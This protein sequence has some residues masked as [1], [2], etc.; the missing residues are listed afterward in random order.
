MGS[1]SLPPANNPPQAL[2]DLALT[3]LIEDRIEK[4]RGYLNFAQE[5]AKKDREYFKYLFDRAVWF[6]GFIVIVAGFLGFR[7]LEQIK[8][9][10]NTLT[11]TEM[12]KA[13]GEL[14]TMRNSVLATTD[15]LKTT[16]KRELDNVRVEVQKRVN[17]E[18][19]TDNITALVTAAAKERTQS[20]LAGTIRSETAKQVAKGIQDQQSFIQG[21]VETE[22]KKAVKALE[23][24]ISSSVDKATTDQV[25]KSVLPIQ[26]QMEGYSDYVRIGTLAILANGDDRHAFDTLMQIVTGNSK[27]SANPSLVHL[28]DSTLGS[29]ISAKSSGIRTTRQFRESQTPDSLKHFMRSQSSWE[30]QAALDNYPS[31]DNSIL[32]LLVEMIETDGSVEV[33]V[34]AVEHFNALTKQS[35]QFFQTQPLLDWW[36]KNKTAFQ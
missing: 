27:D 36:Q 7:S 18:F 14:Q 33:L 19:K 23:P 30:R 1:Q 12:Q 11:K 13:Q 25:N 22:T 24:T 20:E 6:I 10:I 17:D 15:D 5:Q 32:P 35:F 34:R 3:K 16:S 8:D 26:K 28:A 29:I 2:Q 9:E 21:V 31:N 4:E